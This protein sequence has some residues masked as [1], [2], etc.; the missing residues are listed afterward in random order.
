[1][2][3][4]KDERSII[5]ATTFRHSCQFRLGLNLSSVPPFCPLCKVQIDPVG[6]HFFSCK[7]FRQ[8]LT[9]RHDA[10]IRDFKALAS[11]AGIYAQDRNLTIFR[12]LD[13]NDSE[14]PDLLLEREGTNGRD[15]Y[16]D[17]TV[18]HPICQTY[19]NK[20]GKERG[21]TLKKRVKD[22]N[23]KYKEKCERQD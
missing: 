20:A 19:L 16:L 13:E 23:D 14:R 4:K 17:F 22:K 2:H 10:L 9:N 3:P 21:Y 12:A 11:A 8:M 1:M 7:H 6:T 18:S 5:P 15:L